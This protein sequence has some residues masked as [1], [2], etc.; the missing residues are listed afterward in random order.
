MF[1]AGRSDGD[2]TVILFYSTQ[3]YIVGGLTAAP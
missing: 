2:P 1:A 3:G